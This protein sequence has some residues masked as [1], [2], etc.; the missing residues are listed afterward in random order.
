MRDIAAE[1][2][3]IVGFEV[4]AQTVMTVEF[5]PENAGSTLVQIEDLAYVEKFLVF[6][7][8]GGL[9]V[10]GAGADL[11]ETF[12]PVQ[13]TSSTGT[14][15]RQVGERIVDIAFEDALRAPDPV[16]AWLLVVTTYEHADSFGNL[17][18]MRLESD[19]QWT[20]RLS[21]APTDS[22]EKRPDQTLRVDTYEE[23]RS[24][25]LAFADICEEIHELDW[26]D[27]AP[28]ASNLR[29]MA[30]QQ[31]MHLPLRRLDA[32]ADLPAG[33]MMRLHDPYWGELRYGRTRDGVWNA[34]QVRSTGIRVSRDFGTLEEVME[35]ARAFSKGNGHSDELIA[36]FG[37]DIQALSDSMWSKG[38]VEVTAMPVPRRG[39][40]W[41]NSTIRFLHSNRA[42]RNQPAG[43]Q[44][45]DFVALVNHVLG[46]FLVDGPVEPAELTRIRLRNPGAVQQLFSLAESY[47]VSVVVNGEHVLYNPSGV[48][49]EGSGLSAVRV[50]NNG[51]P[52]QGWK[53]NSLA[54]FEEAIDKVA[55]SCQLSVFSTGP[56]GTRGH[57]GTY[58]TCI[59]ENGN[60]LAA[61]LYCPDGTVYGKE[62]MHVNDASWIY[63]IADDIER[64]T[65]PSLWQSSAKMPVL[66]NRRFLQVIRRNG[67]EHAGQFRPV[68]LENIRKH[69]FAEPGDRYSIL[70]LS[71]EDAFAEIRYSGDSDDMPFEME[72]RYTGE[73]GRKRS[74]KIQSAHFQPAMDFLEQF[75]T[76]DRGSLDRFLMGGRA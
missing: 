50:F 23:A 36:A 62:N 43:A 69:G 6:L 20:M 67:E 25:L 46:D 75:A 3:Q 68:A 5:A 2:S 71:Q 55:N 35:V 30:Y 18:S 27:V 29:P 33:T 28:G 54:A 66:E 41:M 19:G 52:F 74:Y 21:Y 12:V 76:G 15:W 49:Q 11:Q 26:K 61:R 10:N 51:I 37:G 42:R 13:L 22:G 53:V 73:D 34:T 65:D 7:D 45:Q 59:L 1:V 57:R 44:M 17:I 47:D 4:P 48:L 70:D 39:A 31:N 8:D 40:P 56:V 64:V 63:S 9:Y 58:E 14:V 38:V 32:V 24:I 60:G 72:C 16:G